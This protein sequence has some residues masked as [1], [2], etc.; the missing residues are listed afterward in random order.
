MASSLLQMLL[1]RV[2]GSMLSWGFNLT[3]ATNR[4]TTARVVTIT[5]GLAK[6]NLV[7][8]TSQISFLGIPICIL[9]DCSV[10]HC[11]VGKILVKRL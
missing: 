1:T 9:I 8:I 6:A 4:G 10:T 11:F 2:Q 3:Q 7:V 5:L